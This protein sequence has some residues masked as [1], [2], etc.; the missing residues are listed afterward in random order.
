VAAIAH[1]SKYLDLGRMTRAQPQASS[2]QIS[3]KCS[4]DLSR[5]SAYASRHGMTLSGRPKRDLCT[6]PGAC[7]AGWYIASSWTETPMSPGLF[8]EYLSIVLHRESRLRRSSLLRQCARVRLRCVLRGLVDGITLWDP[9]SFVCFLGDRR[10]CSLALAGH[11]P[12]YGALCGRSLL[13]NRSFL[14][15]RY[16]LPP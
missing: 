10:T 6:L 2:A 4:G 16:R 8:N 14:G 13:T 9:L 3:A 11:L 7:Q 5:M 12:R 15:V 1:P